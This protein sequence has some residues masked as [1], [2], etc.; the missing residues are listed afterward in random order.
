MYNVHAY[1]IEYHNNCV[2]NEFCIEYWV[3]L[4]IVPFT[5]VRW[6][7]LWVSAE[8]VCQQKRCYKPFFLLFFF[9]FFI[10]FTN[11]NPL[12]HLRAR[13]NEPNSHENFW[14]WEFSLC[15]GLSWGSLPTEEVLQTILFI[16]FFYCFYFFLHLDTSK[17]LR[18]RKNEPNFREFS[19]CSGLGCGSFPTKEV[20]QTWIHLDSSQIDRLPIKPRAWWNKISIQS[21]KTCQNNAASVGGGGL[22]HLSGWWIYQVWNRLNE[23]V[24]DA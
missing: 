24:N 17:F 23:L 20:L 4:K 21:H 18:V 7:F 16:V 14:D 12:G 10:F 11:L 13:K 15:S 9:Y 3:L 1:K 8:E 5:R 6:P 2:A 22:E 19:L